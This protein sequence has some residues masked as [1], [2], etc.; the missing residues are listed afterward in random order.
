MNGSEAVTPTSFQ[1]NWELVRNL[2]VD[3]EEV[4]LNVNIYEMRTIYLTPD[5]TDE[6]LSF[7]NY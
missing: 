4:K 1:A 3:Y 5:L 7:R 6:R 2:L